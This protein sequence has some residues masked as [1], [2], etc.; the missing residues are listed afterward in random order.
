MSYFKVSLPLNDISHVKAFWQAFMVKLIL[1]THTKTFILFRAL[2]ETI[3]VLRC[4]LYGMLTSE[5]T[6]RDEKNLT[7]YICSGIN[8]NIQTQWKFYSIF[9]E[10]SHYHFPYVGKGFTFY[11]NI[12]GLYSSQDSLVSLL[13]QFL[14]ELT[15]KFEI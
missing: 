3:H 4:S 8:R 1:Q 7:K 14:D 11:L 9:S 5:K 2:K 6:Q 10:T 15:D 12:F 13:F